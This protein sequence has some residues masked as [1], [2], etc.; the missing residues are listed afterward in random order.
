MG[1]LF[2]RATEKGD[3][4]EEA[5][6]AVRTL[7]TEFPHLHDLLCG[8]KGNGTTADRL[9]GSLRLFTNGGELKAEITG[10]EWV[11]KGYLIVPKE[12]MS[13]RAIEEQLSSGKIGWSVKTD[14]KDSSSKPPY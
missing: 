2:R 3:I 4:F 13:F 9:P 7:K 10:P 8:K 14:R 11:M 12:D 5:E 6:M 1:D